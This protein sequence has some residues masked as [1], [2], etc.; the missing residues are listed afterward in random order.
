MGMFLQGQRDQFERVAA[1]HRQD[2]SEGAVGTFLPRQLEKK[3]PNTGR[4]FPILT[5]PAAE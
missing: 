3:Y 1:L 4:E 2:L 5:H